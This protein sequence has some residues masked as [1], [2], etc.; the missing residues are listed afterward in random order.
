MGTYVYSIS[1]RVIKTNLPGLPAVNIAKFR[2]RPSNRNYLFDNP[3]AREALQDAREERTEQ[4]FKD[5]PEK[6]TG[7]IALVG[8][9]GKVEIG[10]RIPV[11]QI[12]GTNRATWTDTEQEISSAYI[13]RVGR[14]KWIFV[15]VVGHYRQRNGMR[16]HEHST[17]EEVATY[18]EAQDVDR[19]I[20]DPTYTPTGTVEMEPV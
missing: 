18:Q 12:K 19:L 7:Y 13:Q 17:T 8:D 9:S 15:R 20:P 14:S 6:W 10:K 16:Y 4:A 1:S 5:N 11:F 2:G 3:T